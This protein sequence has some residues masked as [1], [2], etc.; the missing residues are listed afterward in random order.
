MIQGDMDRPS[1]TDLVIS[2]LA[3]VVGVAGSYTAAGW[4][5]AFVVAPIDALI[6]RLTP[7]SLVAWFIVNVGT[8]AHLL[9][10]GLAVVIAVGGLAGTALLGLAIT[11]RTGSMVAGAI[12]TGLLSWALTT[13]LIGQP[14]LAT[15]TAV[16]TA[17][18]TTLGM[19]TSPAPTTAPDKARRR[20]LK[21]GASALAF[22]GIGVA[23]QHLDFSSGR[24]SPT[25]DP[26]SV[27]PAAK[28]LLQQATDHELDIQGD[29]PGLVSQIGEFYLTDIN[30]FDPEYPSDEWDLLITGEV[31]EDVTIDF[32]AL[33]QFP[34]EYRFTTLRCVGESLNGHK[35][36]NAVWTG[37]PIKPLL[38]RADPEGNC[39]CAMLYAK[40][41]YFVQFPVSA[42]EDAFLAWG[43]NGQPLPKSHG[44]PVRLL[45]PGHWG[46]TNVKWVNEIEL[47]DEELDG[48]WE[49][50][51]WHG[52]GPV[53]TVAKLWS[54]TVIDDGRFEVAGFAY[55]GTRG[56]QRVEVST[57]GG[58]TWTDAELSPELPGDD[59]WRQWKHVYDTSGTHEVVVRAVDG[60][61][62]RQPQEQRDSFPTGA[63]GW[64]SKTIRT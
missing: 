61:G 49:R 41:D 43:M 19:N 25:P 62:N 34:T 38:D 57:D 15:A 22:V 45:V 55:A 14:V 46:E 11:K 60:E 58:T 23:S 28:P 5:I 30:Q 48:Y 54:D 18:F 20:V 44:H 7:G 64:V 40:D 12:A 21:A 27:D 51:G 29:L 39:G 50:R 35:L 10:V 13:A 31:G 6:V 42:L 4:S 52:T 24:S 53:E 32:E 56:I 37:T 16:P 59:V 36:D 9:H 8:P 47:L 3:G 63:T 33:Q 2:A 26:D 1:R 17:L